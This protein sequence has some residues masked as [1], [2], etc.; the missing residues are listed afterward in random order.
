L[1]YTKF[2]KKYMNDPSQKEDLDIIYNNAERCKKIVEDLLNF[3]RQTK[4]LHTQANIH[5]TI[6]SV[7]SVVEN[8]FA[9]SAV[10]I[11]RDFDPGLG[12]AILD[13]GKMQQVYMNLIMNAFQAMEQGGRLTISTRSDPESHGFRISF[14]DT[15]CGIPVGFQDRIFDP[16]FTTKEP[17]HGTGLGLTVSYGII[18]EHGGVISMETE[19][20]KG[21][22]FRIWLPL[23]G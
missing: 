8:N 9:E 18:E 23:A 22:T 6:E 17:G 1:G 7:V 3:A 10:V 4:T 19:E 5:E 2:L 20:G 13:V 11:E 16:F 21:S 12:Q 15:G 14:S